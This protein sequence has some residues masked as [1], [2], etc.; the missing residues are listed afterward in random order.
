MKITHKNATRPGASCTRLCRCEGQLEGTHGDAP[1]PGGPSGVPAVT[2][3]VEVNDHPG[4]HIPEQ[5]LSPGTQRQSVF[6]P[7]LSSDGVHAGAPRTSKVPRDL[8]P[9][10]L[11]NCL[12]L[13]DRNKDPE[14]T[15]KTGPKRRRV[16]KDPILMSP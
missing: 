2:L 11:L 1:R 12:Y 13:W 10:T 15:S 8:G 6:L 14:P 4:A 16:P 3:P 9:A 5:P 7:L